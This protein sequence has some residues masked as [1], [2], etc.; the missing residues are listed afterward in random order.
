MITKPKPA[1]ELRDM[2]ATA[3]REIDALPVGQLV[4]QGKHIRLD[5]Q[6]K[7]LF[8]SKPK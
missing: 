6:E 5:A 1:K 2:I 3:R 8:G 7:R 4:R